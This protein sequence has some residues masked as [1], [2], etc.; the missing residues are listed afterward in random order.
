MFK[1]T[2]DK[3]AGSMDPPFTT[4]QTPQYI[5]I[6]NNFDSQL[7]EEGIEERLFL[8][9]SKIEDI[10]GQDL[11]VDYDTETDMD[12]LMGLNQQEIEK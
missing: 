10:E 9:A 8:D 7:I 12:V 11:S 5:N 2:T 1:E 4:A 3:V 6:E